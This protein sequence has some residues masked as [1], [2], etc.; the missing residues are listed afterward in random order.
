MKYFAQQQGPVKLCHQRVLERHSRRRGFS[1]CSSLFLLSGSCTWIQIVS[2]ALGSSSMGTFSSAQ[3]DSSHQAAE[4]SSLQLPWTL[5]PQ[6]G[7]QQSASSESSALE[8]FSLAPYRVNFQQIHQGSITASSLH[9]VSQL[10]ALSNKVQIPASLGGS[11]FVFGLP[12]PYIQDSNIL[13]SCFYFVLANPWVP[14]SPLL[15]ILYM[16]PFLFKVL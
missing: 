5:H 1:S 15:V 14:Q 16:K 11:R 9:P 10:R 7:L 6:G 2:A 8:Q 3:L 4:C 12:A 13:Q